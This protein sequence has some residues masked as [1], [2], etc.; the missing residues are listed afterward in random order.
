M[1]HSNPPPSITRQAATTSGEKGRNSK[2][3]SNKKRNSGSHESHD[4]FLTT[5]IPYNEH[6]KPVD[7]ATLQVK[8]E[9]EQ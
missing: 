8:E 6:D 2:S 3:S 7:I 5:V 9:E 1:F 4:N